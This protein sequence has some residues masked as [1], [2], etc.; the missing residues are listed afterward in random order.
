MKL[1]DANL[2]LYAVNRDAPLFHKATT[3]LSKALAG[4]ETVALTWTV[5]LAFLRLSTRPEVFARPLPAP[6]ALDL[7]DT[8]LSQPCVAVV[9]PGARHR[10]VLRDLLPA[11]TGGH[12]V[13]DAHLAALAMEHGARLYSCDADFARFP[14]L[15]WTNPLA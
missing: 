8:W 1:L 5:L 9:E 14:G 4:P 6:K 15:D 3:W 2:L 7:I 13:M 10:R 12:L 11:G